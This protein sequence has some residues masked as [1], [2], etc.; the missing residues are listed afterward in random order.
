MRVL[1]VE[2]SPRV[3]K[4]IATAL[5]TRGCEVLLAGTA[6]EAMAAPPVDLVLLDLGLPDRDGIEVCR[7]L[8]RGGDVAIIAVTARGTERD[9]VSGL[10]AGADDYVVKPFGVAELFARI[11][12]VMR[13][14]ARPTS[15]REPVS[16]GD[17]TVDLD[18]HKVEV[19]GS[20]IPLTRLEFELLEALARRPG[21]VVTRTQLL[22]DVWHT[23]W[24]G[25]PHTVE[26]HVASLRAK[27]GKPRLIQTIRGVGYRLRTEEP[28]T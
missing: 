23:T 22:A 7:Q 27:L 1:V 8:R 25:N 15:R 6:A 13:R 12:A 20:V 19:G 26:V 28:G 24:A 4:G 21:V 2:D 16:I 3:A 9:C 11:D 5:R 10:G 18:A 14:A 17:F